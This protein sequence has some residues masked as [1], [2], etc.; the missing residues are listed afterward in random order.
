MSDQVVFSTW[1][2]LE[3]WDDLR[4][5]GKSFERRS[6]G[7][8]PYPSS[9]CSADLREVRARTQCQ[10]YVSPSSSSRCR[11]AIVARRLGSGRDLPIDLGEP[12]LFGLTYNPLHRDSMLLHIPWN[13][14]KPVFP[15]FFQPN[16]SQIAIQIDPQVQARHRCMGPPTKPVCANPRA[17]DSDDL[18]LS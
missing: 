4:A 5:L 18:L 12:L 2:W 3:L 13:H 11:G 10:L 15:F 1:G 16:V 14:S 8:K 6:F 17:S 7:Q 9:M